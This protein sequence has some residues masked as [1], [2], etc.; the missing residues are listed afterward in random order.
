MAIT[1]INLL[2]NRAI[3][4]QAAY[5]KT[6]LGGLDR[7]LAD[8][9]KFTLS[10][11]ANF[12][13]KY[14]FIATQPNELNGF[15]AT[16]YRETATSR[17]I[18]AARG[19]EFDSVG[20]ITGDF[21]SADAL[22]IGAL[23]YANY[24]AA[25]MYRYWKRLTTVGDQAVQYSEGELLQLFTIQNGLTTPAILASP[26]YSAFKLEVRNDK[27][28]VAGQDAGTALIDPTTK[29]DVVGHSLGGHLAET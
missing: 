10:Q 6:E 2:A 7:A 28:V 12:K 24:Q 3:L 1:N 18:L 17:L 5:G 11:I 14:E 23:G 25:S 19:T 26:A 29:V 15:S 13:S 9:A 27:G 21:I 20:G 4:A 22:G 16:V 8:D